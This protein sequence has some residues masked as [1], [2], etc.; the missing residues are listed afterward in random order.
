MTQD[1][2]CK[3]P[4]I[5]RIGKLC[6]KSATTQSSVALV[7][8]HARDFRANIARATRLE[9]EEPVYTAKSRYLC[10]SRRKTTTLD[11]T[12][13]SFCSQPEDHDITSSHPVQR[14]PRHSNHYWFVS[15]FP[16]TD[17]SLLPLAQI[18]SRYRD[19]AKDADEAAAYTSARDIL[20]SDKYKR[21]T[22]AEEAAAYTSVGD[23][24][25]GGGK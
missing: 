24:W 23:I 11:S 21:A 10:N 3:K 7:D 18:T 2:F 15:V 14:R 9:T 25:G 1:T 4:L 22:D 6:S 20:G 8:C 19:A 5:C 12:S 17:S 16:K 13:R